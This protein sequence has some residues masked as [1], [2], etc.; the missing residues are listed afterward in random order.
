MLPQLAKTSV[1]LLKLIRLKRLIKKKKAKRLWVHPMLAVQKNEGEFATLF[2]KLRDDEEKFFCYMRMT[3]REF[4]LLLTKIKPSLELKSH[5]A[6]T[7]AEQLMI[8]LRFFA[9]GMQFRGLEYTF[10][11]GNST[12]SIIVSRVSKAIWS[13]HEKYL[14][15]PSTTEEWINIANGFEQRWN[16]PFCIGA[17]DGKLVRVRKPAKSGSLYH[18]YKHH[19]SLNLL[20]LCD[21]RYRLTFV[22]IGE[23]GYK[24]DANVFAT[25]TLKQMLTNNS[26]KIPESTSLPGMPDSKIHY[27]IVADAAFPLSLNIMKPFSGRILS[28]EQ[29]IYNYRL[30][31]A[32]RI[33]ENVF[34]IMCAKWRLLLKPIETSIESANWIVRAIVVLHNFN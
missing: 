21:H 27:F 1:L 18:D 3:S 24:G 11:R 2:P 28:R 14:T 19:F 17:L 30:S 23:Y 26:F 25:S 4:D 33:I 5:R 31:R 10:R 13:L 12:I 29:R 7:P 32:R 22:D 20:A 9:T 34:G 6:I 16:M 15:L 8:T